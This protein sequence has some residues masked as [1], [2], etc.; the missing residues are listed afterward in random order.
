MDKIEALENFKKNLQKEININKEKTNNIMNMEM[1]NKGIEYAEKGIPYEEIVSLGFDN[2][3][4]FMQGYNEK[5]E[6][7]NHKR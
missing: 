4:S 2:E 6:E 1:Y 7:L 5:L 3:V